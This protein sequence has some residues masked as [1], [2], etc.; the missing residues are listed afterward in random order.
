MN[1]EKAKEIL[2]KSWKKLSEEEKEEF[3]TELS[4]KEIS[5]L[6]DGLW[7]EKDTKEALR[8]IGQELLSFKDQETNRIKK[9]K[10]IS[11]IG[12]SAISGALAGLLDIGIGGA[13]GG[14]I[15]GAVI[16]DVLS[17]SLLATFEPK[18]FVT[19]RDRKSVV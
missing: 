2:V 17:K 3:L 14:I 5:L 8:A 6:E 13:T 19:P 15:T 11:I 16:A 7:D 1:N 18:P 10:V 9:K 4:N 12:S